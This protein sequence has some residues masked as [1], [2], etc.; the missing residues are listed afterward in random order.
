MRRAWLPV[1][2]ACLCATAACR[3][4]SAPPVRCAPGPWA[5]VVAACPSCPS[6]Q[7]SSFCPYT[8]D[9]CIDRERQCLRRGSCLEQS[10]AVVRIDFC[11]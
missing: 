7:E 6:P 8:Q 9:Y 10:P 4:R 11:P 1:L 3:E 2:I 5:E